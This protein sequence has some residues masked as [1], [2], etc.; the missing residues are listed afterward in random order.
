MRN[1]D[2]AKEYAHE[3]M[4]EGYAVVIHDNV[5]ILY[6]AGLTLQEARKYAGSVN[7]LQPA[8]NMRR[9]Q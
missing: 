9:L 7:R 3:V 2:T 1:L 8:P 4:L 5:D 6:C